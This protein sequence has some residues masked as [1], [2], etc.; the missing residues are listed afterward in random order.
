V[1]AYDRIEERF[2]AGKKKG[3]DGRKRGRKSTA[4]KENDRRGG[5]RR[6]IRERSCGLGAPQ[7]ITE[8]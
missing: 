8:G 6:G 3:I 2:K 4:E 5:P 1:R 7:K